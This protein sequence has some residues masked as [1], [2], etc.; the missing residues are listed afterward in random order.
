MH[1]RK[2]LVLVLIGVAILVLTG[3]EEA[4]TDAQN[5]ELVVVNGTSDTQITGIDATAFPF[6][7]KATDPTG[8]FQFNEDNPLGA[9]EQFAITLSPYV[10]R[11]TVAVSFSVDSDE[12]GSIS[13]RLTIDLPAKPTQPTYI[14][15]VL[16]DDGGLPEYTFEVTGDYVDHDIPMLV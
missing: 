8:Y 7:Q 10:Y 15:L 3:C 12:S 4:Q 1:V 9:E 14:T 11:V 5:R 16:N 2:W 13:R 6:G